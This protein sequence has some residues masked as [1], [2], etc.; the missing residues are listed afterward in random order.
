MSRLVGS[1]QPGA[2]RPHKIKNKKWR[3]RVTLRQFALHLAEVLGLD[4]SPLRGMNR[5]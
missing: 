2:I 1:L 3:T 5:E 4:D